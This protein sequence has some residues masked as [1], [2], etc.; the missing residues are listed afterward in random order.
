MLKDDQVA[1][2]AQLSECSHVER[3]TLGSS[4][5]R[6]TIFFYPLDIWWLNV[7]PAKAMSINKCLSR[8]TSVGRFGDESN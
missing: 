8:G 4:P 3:E 2:L 6:A 1:R 7:G 5:G